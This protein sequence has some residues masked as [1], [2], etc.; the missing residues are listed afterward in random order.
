VAHRLEIEEEGEEEV[1]AAVV[2]HVAIEPVALSVAA[3]YLP[4]HSNRLEEKCK[5][6]N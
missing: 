3:K 2:L 4:M 5:F 6:N 1:A